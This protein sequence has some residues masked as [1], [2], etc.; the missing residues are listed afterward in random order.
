[1]NFQAVHFNNHKRQITFVYPD[2]SQF[3]LHYSGLGIAETLQEAWLYNE[4]PQKVGIF[5]SSGEVEFVPTE[6]VIQACSKGESDLESRLEKFVDEI[7][8]RLSAKRISKRHLAQGM[9]TSETQIYR[10]LDRDHLKRRFQPLDQIA[11]AV[12]TELE[13]RLQPKKT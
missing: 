5:Y 12:D 11:A 13:F 6:K 2:Q 7:E 1:M 10:L 9:K 3:S 8:N 4:G